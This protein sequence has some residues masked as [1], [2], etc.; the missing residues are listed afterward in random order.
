MSSSEFNDVIPQRTLR[1]DVSRVLREVRDGRT[2]QITV[3]GHPV[4][5][6]RP[7]DTRARFVSASVLNDILR[8]APLDAGFVADVDA[9]IGQTI[10]EL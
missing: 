6:L 8:S 4:A 7:I 10:D 3:D 1:N 5:E 9:I 2:F